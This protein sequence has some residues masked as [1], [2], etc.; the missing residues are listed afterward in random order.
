MHLKKLKALIWAKPTLIDIFCLGEAM[1][2][3]MHRRESVHQPRFGVRLSR[4]ILYAS[5]Y[6]YLVIRLSKL[7]TSSIVHKLVDTSLHLPIGGQ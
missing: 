3:V 2:Y 7:A 6:F 4:H 5:I 1:Q